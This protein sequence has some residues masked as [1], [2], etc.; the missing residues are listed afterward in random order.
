MWYMLLDGIYVF[1]PEVIV[2]L[3]EMLERVL[4]EF[5]RRTRG[6]ADKRVP[7]ILEVLGQMVFRALDDAHRSLNSGVRGRAHFLHLVAQ[8]PDLAGN[9]ELT[10]VLDHVKNSNPTA[11]PIFFKPGGVMSKSAKTEK[12]PAAVIAPRAGAVTPPT[13]I[14]GKFNSTVGCTNRK[15]SRRH[16]RPTTVAEEDS[17]VAFFSVGGGSALTRRG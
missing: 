3:L 16:K 8:I 2:A 13:D 9:S 5:D 12:A 1:A 15:C 4:A 11:F 10:S 7:F 17:L 14:C 6:E